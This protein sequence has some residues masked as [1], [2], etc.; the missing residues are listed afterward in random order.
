MHDDDGKKSVLGGG[1]IVG[2]GQ[3]AGKRVPGHRQRLGV[4]GGTV[5]PMGLKKGLR[6]QEP[7][8]ARTSC[9]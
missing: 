7:S 8:R 5:S 3:V 2:V 1:T 9:P 4:K 6:A